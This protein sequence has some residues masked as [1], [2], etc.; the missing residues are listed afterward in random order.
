MAPFYMNTG[1]AGGKDFKV[2]NVKQA[3]S[4]IAFADSVQHFYGPHES[5]WTFDQSGDGDPD[6][7]TAWHV[8]NLMS[9]RIHSEGCNIGLLDGHVE[10][11]KF[12]K[13]YDY[14]DGFGVAK[15]TYWEFPY[16][17]AKPSR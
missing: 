16:A 11:I 2:S 17:N 9:A 6:S 15:H 10:Y 7:L 1:V 8:Y 13:L 14:D 12:K 3:G 5:P 4:K